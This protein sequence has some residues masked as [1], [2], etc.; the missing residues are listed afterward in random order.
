M[1][2][3]DHVTISS[4]LPH[5]LISIG[6]SATIDIIINIIALNWALKL[7]FSLLYKM[8]SFFIPQIHFIKSRAENAHYLH[9]LLYHLIVLGWIR[10]SKPAQVMLEHEAIILA[11]S[12]TSA[13][14]DTIGINT[15][16]LRRSIV[17]QTVESSQFLSSGTQ[18]V[19]RQTNENL[20]RMCV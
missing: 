15:L 1:L 2:L 13:S 3:R 12:P 9:Y 7:Y 4:S 20:Q 17:S 19:A 5:S 8:Q 18:V 11:H 10:N 16:S 6:T 14:S